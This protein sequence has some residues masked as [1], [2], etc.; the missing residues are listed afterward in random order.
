MNKL[1]ANRILLSVCACWASI[2]GEVG[3]PLNRLL[4]LFD[5]V[6]LA[7]SFFIMCT[8]SAK[9]LAR[10][11]SLNLTRGA[12]FKGEDEPTLYDLLTINY[13]PRINEFEKLYHGLVSVS[14]GT[15][16]F[17]RL[18]LRFYRAKFFKAIA[19]ATTATKNKTAVSNHRDAKSQLVRFFYWGPPIVAPTQD[20]EQTG[21][22]VVRRFSVPSSAGSSE[23]SLRFGHRDSLEWIELFEKFRVGDPAACAREVARSLRSFR[24]KRGDNDAKRSEIPRRPGL[25]FG[26]KKATRPP[27]ERQNHIIFNPVRS[28]NFLEDDT[29]TRWRHISGNL[30]HM[31][32]LIVLM[33]IPIMY[34]TITGL[35]SVMINFSYEQLDTRLKLALYCYGV[36]EQVYSCTQAALFFIFT[37]VFITIFHADIQFK[38][39]K[40]ERDFCQLIVDFRRRDRLESAQNS[41][42]PPK[43]FIHY[44]QLRLWALFDYIQQVDSF[45]SKY[46]VVSMSTFMIGLSFGQSFLKVEEPA[47]KKGTAAVMFANF[48]SFSFLYIISWDI[49]RRVS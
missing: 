37:N 32:V 26:C 45:V 43:I 1:R 14:I 4:Q 24:G 20:L 22:K 49:E 42:R 46:S 41:R 10:D 40:I 27:A 44:Q 3:L 12:C 18:Y 35:Y 23:L 8:S 16:F 39:N 31:L 9:F 30:A 29:W 33:T 7:W 48:L 38:M 17:W 21:A 28:Y 5:S 25:I 11:L 13:L 2:N 6:T 19:A 34:Y 36:L 15:S 47:L